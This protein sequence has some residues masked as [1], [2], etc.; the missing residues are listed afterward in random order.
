MPTVH[1]YELANPFYDIET[2]DSIYQDKIG[3][4]IEIER[5]LYQVGFLEFKRV[6]TSFNQNDRFVR[7]L[8]ITK[9]QEKL[10]NAQDTLETLKQIS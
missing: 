5:V 6:E 4:F 9:N 2:E 10:S 8:R 3:K 7:Y 1:Y